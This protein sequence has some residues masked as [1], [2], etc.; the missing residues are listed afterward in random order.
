[1]TEEPH[2]SET[3]RSTSAEQMPV[4]DAIKET[5]SPTAPGQPEDS[6]VVVDLSQVVPGTTPAISGVSWIG[7]CA[8]FLFATLAVFVA[9][10]TNA[11]QTFDGHMHTWAVAHRG[12]LGT[13]IARLITRGGLS[14]LTL[15]TLV[16]VGALVPGGHKAARTRLGAGVLLAAVAGL[17]GFLE[18]SLNTW[19]HRAR[20]PV[21]DWAGTA[22]GASFPS[23]HT[24]AATL[25]ALFC[26]WA[27]TARTRPGWTRIAL[28]TVAGVYALAVGWSRIWLGVH[29]PTDVLGAWMYGVAWLA[30]SAWAM[31]VVRR[32]WPRP[33]ITG[34][35]TVPVEPH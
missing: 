3:D 26:A 20:P 34:T 18:L 17:G 32:R 21:S 15:P 10:H 6:G 9:R 5:L 2:D 24:T 27:L 4:T 13:S 22:G 31:V 30:L 29:W 11:I 16:V 23:G 1:M 19:I 12:H 28:W 14:A 25:F 33:S 35:P 8:A 7:I